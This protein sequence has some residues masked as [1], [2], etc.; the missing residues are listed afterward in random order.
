M[1][2][3]RSCRSAGTGTGSRRTACPRRRTP[4]DA[5]RMRSPWTPKEGFSNEP[6]SLFAMAKTGPSSMPPELAI[7]ELSH[8]VDPCVSSAGGFAGRSIT[9]L[10]LG[11]VLPQRRVGG[12]LLGAPGGRLA[13][14]LGIVVRSTTS[15]GDQRDHADRH[16]MAASDHAIALPPPPRRVLA[17]LSDPNRTRDRL[18][19]ILG[20]RCRK[21]M[22]RSCAVTSRP[23]KTAGWMAWRGTGTPTSS[24][25]AV[26]GAADDVG[27]IRGESKLRRYYQDWIDTMDGLRADVEEVLFDDDERVAAVVRNSGRGRASGVPHEGALLRR[28]HGP[29]R[30]DCQWP[31]VRDARPGPR[32][33]GVGVGDV[34][35]ER[36]DRAQ[37][38]RG[39]G[40]PRL[41]GGG[42]P[43]L[44]RRGD[45]RHRPRPESGHLPR[46]RRRDA[47]P[48]RDRRDVGRISCRDR[49]RCL[50][51]ATRSSCWFA[52]ADWVE[53]SGAQVDSRAAWV[54]A[55]REQRITRLRLYRDR[56]RALAAVG[57][58]E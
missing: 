43:F 1:S 13:G 34:A 30:S 21:R 17:S 29:G 10:Q 54:A 32:G 15:D 27:V 23:S 24:G 18:P 36:G 3:S 56:S 39:L 6:A 4:R 2:A 22:W 35:G 33:R 49:G 28:L 26:E 11:R 16:Q 31:R 5:S 9:R 53:P 55:V 47:L 44:P 38:L 45:R 48:R 25:Q 41:R 58:S 46:P 50:R 40:S 37:R 8:C 14:R 20:A 51:R 12:S 42:E 57:L 52:R 19:G 7:V